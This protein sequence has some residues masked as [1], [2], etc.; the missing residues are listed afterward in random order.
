MSLS[1]FV[2]GIKR[3][4]YIFFLMCHAISYCDM[5][6][7]TTI[8]TAQGLV[9]VE[10]INVGDYVIG[11][12]NNTLI[13]NEVLKIASDEITDFVFTIVIDQGVIQATKNQFFYDPVIGQWIKTKNLTVNSIFV[14]N[15]LRHCVCQNITSHAQKTIIYKISTKYPHNF[16][17]SD[18]CILIH[19]NPFVIAL[20]WVFGGGIEFLGVTLG[21][22][23]GGS[24]VGV[25]L[26]DKYK[27]NNVSFDSRLETDFRHGG[28]FSDSGNNDQ[29]SNDGCFIPGS[30]SISAID[31]AS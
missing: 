11:Y 29:K 3:F 17:I 24:V 22:V 25:K 10:E 5:V 31:L 27:K 15:D 18:A 9:P 28:C 4:F 30:A 13:E 2:L 14:R 6:A 23:F 7:G 16:F 21:A 20:E 26:Y 8:L 12:A 19:N 1:V